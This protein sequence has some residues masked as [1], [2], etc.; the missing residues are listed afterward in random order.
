MAEWNT[1]KTDWVAGDIPMV[2]DFNRIEGNID[3]L[4]QDIETK[5]GTIVNAI[6]DMNQSAQVTDTYA[7]LASKIRDISK[8]ATAAVGDV[9]K[10]KTFYAGG[11]KRTGTL[12]LTGNATTADVLSGKTFYN[13]NLKSKA[14]GAMPNRGAVV[15][16]PR[17]SNQAIQA[18][19]HNG[20]G[21]VKGD[22][23]LVAAN[24]VAGKSIFGV[25]GSTI[26]LKVAIGSVHRQG[27]PLEEYITVS[28]LDFTP[29]IIIAK[30]FNA[31]GSSS[32]GEGF[33]VWDLTSL[34]GS[35]GGINR[36]RS[37]TYETFWDRL[38]YNI[39][40]A[41]GTFTAQVPSHSWNNT[42]GVDY[43]VCGW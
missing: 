34:G 12:E 17:T 3:F 15:I 37:E 16:T 43:V 22:S 35:V 19:Y 14:T 21:Y 6:N 24:I 13:T 40:I 31:P 42:L 30:S 38:P 18:G 10:G 9:E 8:D 20:S 28:G 23:N 27:N 41:Y 1:P 25:E 29:K 11:Q 5:K 39:T 32:L 4:K 33:V 7:Q 2:D 26:G 36:R